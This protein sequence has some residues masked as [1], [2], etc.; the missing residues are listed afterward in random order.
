MAL[1]SRSVTYCDVSSLQLPFGSK[2]LRLLLLL[3]PPLL[4]PLALQ[5]TVGFGLSNNVLPFFPICHQLS[6]SSHSQHLNSLSTSS[7]T[8]AAKYTPRACFQNA[9]HF[10]LFFLFLLSL[11]PPPISSSSLYPYFWVLAF[12]GFAI[13]S[14]KR[15]FT[16]YSRAKQFPI[17]STHSRYRPFMMCRMYQNSNRK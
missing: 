15:L 16:S 1:Y 3:P 10:L 7:Q 4:L 5:P 17:Y 6:P 2:L 14:L 13:V 11:P 12:H 8:I 9:S